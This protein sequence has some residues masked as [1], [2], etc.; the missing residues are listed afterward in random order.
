MA[1]SRIKTW[2]AEILTASDLNA[3]YDNILN[4]GAKSLSSPREAALDMAGFELILDAD[5]NSSFTADTDDRL[6]VRLQ[7]K[8]LFL[9]D[10]T[11]ASSVDGL[12][13][14]AVA[15]ASPSTVTITGQGESTNINVNLVSKGTSGTIQIEGNSAAGYEDETTVIAQQVFS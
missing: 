9:F 14:G 11:T 5:A 10:G 6:D 3:E 13:F 1:L 4:E 2:I 12:T 8:D 15:T 7:G